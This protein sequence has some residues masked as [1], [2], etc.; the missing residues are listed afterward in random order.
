MNSVSSLTAV[1]PFTVTTPV[2]CAV[3]SD[4]SSGDPSGLSGC[5]AE[6]FSE[7]LC[8]GFSETLLSLSDNSL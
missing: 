7:K 2:C 3:L 8:D 6:L 1:Y 4:E 5:E